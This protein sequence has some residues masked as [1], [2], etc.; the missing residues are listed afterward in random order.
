MSGK[1]RALIS[2]SDKTGIVDFAKVLVGCGYEI[3]STGGTE[4]ALKDGGV[5][6]VNI[7]DITGFPECLGGR[8]KTLH[9]NIY[10]GILAVRGNAEHMAQLADLKVGIIDIIVVNLYP[11]K[12]TI[13]KQPPVSLEEAVENIDIGGPAMLR[14]AAKN[15]Q[16]VAV[17]VDPDDYNL[18]AEQLKT[19]GID[20]RLKLKLACKAFEYTAAYDVLIAEYLRKVTANDKFPDSLSFTYEKV[21]EMRYGENPHQRGVF[22]KEVAN[23]DGTVAASVQLHGKELS[24]L[25]IN[26]ANG[27]LE[28]LKEFAQDIPAAVVV[29]HATPC[30]VGVGA[31]IYEAYMNAYNA[32]PLSI[33]GGIVALNQEVDAATAEKMAEIFLEIIIAPSFSKAAFDILTR[34][35]NIRLLELKYISKPN[36]SD[37][38]DMKKVPGGLLVQE[39]NAE[40]IDNAELKTVTKKQ[41]SEKEMPE[42]L[43]AF[44]VVKHAKSNGIVLA[45]DNATVGIGSGQTNRITALELALKYAGDRACGAVMASDAFF[46]MADCVEA[47]HK[48]GITAIIQPGGSI[49][50]QESIDACDKYNIAMVFTGIRHFKH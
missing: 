29:K 15:W 44:K 10:A 1:G 21:Q 30:G 45:K 24:Y 49:R 43:F 33:F 38:Y 50:D 27:A 16:D 40:F 11:F 42:L 20:R 14:A 9:P 32:D 39:F 17:I 31:S 8:V 37:I 25:N 47:A 7:S 36:L 28:L 18:I 2:V 22:Y 48:A 35:Q 6:T 13:L 23:L 41:P 46:P 4:Q 26:D 19:G 12:E 5:A 3:I 34:K